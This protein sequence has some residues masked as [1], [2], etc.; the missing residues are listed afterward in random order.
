M[1]RIDNSI[2]LYEENPNEN[3]DIPPFA[4]VKT[5]EGKYYSYSPYNW[6]GYHLK[7]NIDE[8][9]TCDIL[10]HNGIWRKYQTTFTPNGS[11]FE[12]FVMPMV[13][14]EMSE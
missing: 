10:L 2:E 5:K 12:T 3:I 9:G 13:R 14:S 7:R 6:V 1:F 11:D 4:V 8:N